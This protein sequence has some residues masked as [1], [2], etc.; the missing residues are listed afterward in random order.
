MDKDKD[1][2]DYKLYP[3][4]DPLRDERIGYDVYKK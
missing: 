2:R 1:Y 4:S 3:K